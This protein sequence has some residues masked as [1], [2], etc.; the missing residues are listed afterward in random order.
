MTTE[1]TAYTT[2]VARAMLADVRRNTAN[3][4]EL[5]TSSLLWSAIGQAEGVALPHLASDDLRVILRLY[6]LWTEASD[7]VGPRA[8]EAR[9]C[10]RVAAEGFERLALLWSDAGEDALASLAWDASYA[11]GALSTLY[12]AEFR[13][14]NP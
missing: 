11:A 7:V 13:P 4:S 5:Q 2:R 1:A 12:D 9:D 6:S 3:E 8:A 10:W 14:C